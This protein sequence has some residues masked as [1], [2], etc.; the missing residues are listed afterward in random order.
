MSKRTTPAQNTTTDHMH[1]GRRWAQEKTTPMVEDQF[2]E[3]RA[4]T[5]LLAV[6]VADEEEEEEE[7]W[8]SSL[9]PSIVPSRRNSRGITRGKWC[10][11]AARLRTGWKRAPMAPEIQTPNGNQVFSVVCNLPP[12]V[13][14]V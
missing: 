11:C 7:S 2:Y 3:R 1:H 14:P 12:G 8:K 13:P 4:A 6:G 5:L 10:T 9:A